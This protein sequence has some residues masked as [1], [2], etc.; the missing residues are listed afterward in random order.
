MLVDLALV[1]VGLDPLD[2]L[3]LAGLHADDGLLELGGK[4]HAVQGDGA[5]LGGEVAGALDVLDVDA[6]DVTLGDLAVLVG[7]L[8]GHLVGEELVELPVNL[9]LGNLLGGH[10]DLGGVIALELGLG[11]DVDGDGGLV[12]GVLHDEGGLVA[13]GDLAQRGDVELLDDGGVGGVEQVV[14][15]L[16]E[17]GLE[18]HHVVDDGAGNVAATEALEGVLVGDLRVGLLDGR[19]DV[20]GRDG[21]LGGQLVVLRLLRGDGDVQRSS[22][23]SYLGGLLPSNECPVERAHWCG[24]KDSNLHGVSPTGT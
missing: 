17:D 23:V 1:L 14:G 4:L 20:G 16:G 11:A 15:G 10:V 2:V 6:D 7:V 12:V 8:V 21:D 5:V 24:R 3:G 13:E 9:C 22:S 18:A 19:V